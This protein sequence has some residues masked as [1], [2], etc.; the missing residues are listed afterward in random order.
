MYPINRI[1]LLK[2]LAYSSETAPVKRPIKVTQKFIIHAILSHAPLASRVSWCQVQSANTA[3]L[4]FTWAIHSVHSVGKWFA[5]L[6]TGRFRSGITFTICT[7]QFHLPKNGRE[8]L[9]LVSEMPLIEEMEQE[10]PFGIFHREK[11]EKF[12]GHFPPV[13]NCYP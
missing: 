4:P 3:C 11:Q 10:F 7:N 2:N 5:K 8:G 6:R 12:T 13:V 1:L 9:K